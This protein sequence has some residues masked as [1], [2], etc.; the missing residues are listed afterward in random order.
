MKPGGG[1]E[2][3]ARA[4]REIAKFF[5]E[6]MEKI[7]AEVLASHGITSEQSTEVRRT[8]KPMFSSGQD[9]AGVPGLSIEV[10]HVQAN[11]V[12][13]HWEQCKKQAGSNVLHFPV[14]F[15]KKDR[16]PWRVRSFASLQNPAASKVD[17]W[18]VA[19]YELWEFLSWYGEYYRDLL[20]RGYTGNIQG[21]ENN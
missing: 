12:D 13:K 6:L 9:I 17:R 8:A 20:V 14:L 18:I 2:K 15:Y 4:E 21:N 5:A 1:R 7:E 16:Y 11:L 3:G 19:N 10:K